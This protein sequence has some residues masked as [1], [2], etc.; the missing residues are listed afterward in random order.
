MLLLKK[1][2]YITEEEIK[3]RKEHKHAERSITIASVAI[4]LSGVSLL[5]TIAFSLW[6]VT[7]VHLSNDSIELRPLNSELKSI[8]NEIKYIHQAD[9]QEFIGAKSKLEIVSVNVLN[10]REHG[11]NKSRISGKLHLVDEVTIIR[12][13]N[14]WSNIEWKQGGELCIK[15][16][17]SDEMISEHK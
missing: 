10:V 4:I 9:S 15:G 13:S 7:D 1:N 2:D 6:G 17:V 16:W 8:N 5:C 3:S 11:N 12:K 14:N